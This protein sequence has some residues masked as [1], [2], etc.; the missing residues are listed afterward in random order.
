M[1]LFFNLILLLFITKPLFSENYKTIYQIK[2]RGLTIGELTWDLDIKSGLYSTTIYL[3]NKGFL[4][5]F[6]EFNGKYESFGTIKDSYLFPNEYNQAWDTKNKSKIVKIIYKNKK[7]NKIFLLPLEK[8]HPRIKFKE[9]EGYSDPLTSFLNIL[10]S[11]KPHNTIDGRRAYLLRPTNNEKSIKI[12]VDEYKNIWADHKRNDLEFIEI[13][14]NKDSF[15]PEKIKI[16]FK[17]SIFL[18]MQN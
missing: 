12:L 4:S 2:N 16:M 13:F 3:K 6:Y 7:I 9:L 18:L 15:L 1:K 14:T 11:N 10:I 5:S 17:G 8:E